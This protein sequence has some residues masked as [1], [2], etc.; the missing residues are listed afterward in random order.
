MQRGALDQHQI[1]ITRIEEAID[2]SA[3]KLNGFYGSAFTLTPTMRRQ[4]V[5]DMLWEV[6]RH[7]WHQLTE[8][9]GQMT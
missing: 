4:M 9:I 8:Q 6:D 3:I 1:M 7:Q 5:S 2:E